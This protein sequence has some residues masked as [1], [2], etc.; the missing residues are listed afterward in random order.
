[1]RVCVRVLNLE[2]S[3]VVPFASH[4][5]DESR[6]FAIE[7]IQRSRAAAEA[8]TRDVYGDAPRPLSGPALI[9][10]LETNMW[11]EYMLGV[12]GPAKLMTLIGDDRVDLKHL[13]ATQIVDEMRHSQVFAARARELGGRGELLAHEPTPEDWVLIR[14]TLDFDH[15][16]ELVT[17]LNCTGEVILQ[18]TFIRLTERGAGRAAVVDDDTATLMERELI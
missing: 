18:Q 13:L 2:D 4:A 14:A 7:L 3:P 1:M 10:L 11:R 8:F 15:P 16:A 12:Q 6:R 17:S 9:S 5:T